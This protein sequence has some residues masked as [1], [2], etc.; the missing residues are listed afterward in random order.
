[1]TRRDL[2]TRLRPRLLPVTLAVGAVVLGLHVS[3]TA[4][5]LGLGGAPAVA[6]TAQPQAQRPAA[7]P[8]PRPAAAQAPR[9]AAPQNRTEAQLL[10]DI[11][12]Q[13]AGSTDDRLRQLE[14]RERLLEAAEKRVDAKLQE[15]RAIEQRIGAAQTKQQA[16]AEERFASLVRVYETMKPKDAARIFEKLDLPVQV[17][18]ATR[19]K[20]AKMAPI[21]ASMAPEAA[22]TLT[23]ELAQRSQL[24][25][26]A[27]PRPGA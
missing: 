26:V 20:T 23:M 24:Q 21:M 10:N 12:A 3:E 16:D 11:A 17:A 22:R 18:V 5:Q 14:L 7:Q 15:V 27:R 19:M 8:A 1:M 6:Q 4:M 13:R 25:A 9:P 2:M